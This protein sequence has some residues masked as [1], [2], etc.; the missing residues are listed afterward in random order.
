MG[1]L[2]TITRLLR[3]GGTVDAPPAVAPGQ[4]GILA[5]TP[6]AAYMRD[7]R[8]TTFARWSPAMRS[9]QDE[10]AVSWDHAT[11]RTFDLAHNSGWI[12]GMIDQATAN[13]VGLGLRL[14]AM[15]ENDLIG[16]SEDDAQAWVSDRSAAAKSG[17]IASGTSL[18]SSV[19]TCPVLSKTRIISG[20]SCR[21]GPLQPD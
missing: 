17:K 14:R 11:A 6:R 5:P 3:G 10:V 15:P 4:G 16:M 21:A 12:A 1:A 18:A 8:G 13:T 20:A 19:A 2:S 7:G 9:A